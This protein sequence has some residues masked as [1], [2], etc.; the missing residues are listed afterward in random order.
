MGI[1]DGGCDLLWGVN[2]HRYNGRTFLS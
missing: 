2:G 1:Q